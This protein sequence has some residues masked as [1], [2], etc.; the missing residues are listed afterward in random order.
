[1]RIIIG[2]LLRRRDRP[3]KFVSSF[4]DLLRSSSA[5]LKTALIN[6]EWPR[7]SGSH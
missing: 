5:S 2:V 6:S 3:S 4:L 7:E 1:M